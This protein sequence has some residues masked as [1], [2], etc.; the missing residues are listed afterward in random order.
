[1][2]EVLGSIPRTT[3]PHHLMPKSQG[4]STDEEIMAIMMRPWISEFMMFLQKMM[5]VKVCKCVCGRCEVSIWDDIL[6]FFKEPLCMCLHVRM[7]MYIEKD[8]E[9]GRG[10]GDK[11]LLGI[12]LCNY[13]GW[14]IPGYTFGKLG[15]LKSWWCNSNL[16]L[17]AWEPGE[18]MV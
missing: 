4:N 13:R 7:C 18:L 14:E 17:E 3:T 8:R 2:Q 11:D 10:G 6:G 16:S 12:G 9:R 15:T 1:M 5:N